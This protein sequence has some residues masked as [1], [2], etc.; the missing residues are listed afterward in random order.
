MPYLTQFQEKLNEYDKDAC[1]ELAHQWV[2]SGQ[3]GL[4][5]FYETILAKAM[6]GVTSK[7]TN[8]KHKIWDEH[9]KTQILRTVLESL[10]P[11]VLKK[12]FQVSDKQVAIVC[13]EGEYHELGPRVV[14]DYF[15]ILGYNAHFFGNSLPKEEISDLMRSFDFDYVVLSTNN[16]YNLSAL[17]ATIGIINRD[18]P[19]QKII[20][21]GQALVNNPDVIHGNKV[22]VCQN[23]KELQAVV[24]GDVK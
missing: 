2:S 15:R 18:H 1:V 5:E 20:L 3:L 24:K 17:N 4:I 9:M 23:F 19:E 22:F 7:E 14:A 10:Y 21:G 6:T 8:P 11:I 16:F 12:S 13:P